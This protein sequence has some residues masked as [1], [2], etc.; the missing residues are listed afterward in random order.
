MAKVPESFPAPLPEGVEHWPGRLD[1]AAQ[2]ALLGAVRERVAR[3]PLFVPRMPRTGRAMSVR[4]TNFG[5]LGWVTDRA[6]GYRYQERHPETGAAWPDIPRMLMDLW[7]EL[8]GDPRAPQACLVNF[9][10][11]NAKMGL[12]QDRDEAVFDAPVLSVSLG[13]DAR[14]RVGGTQRGARTQSFRL[15]SGDVVRLGGPARLAHHGVDRIYAGTSDLLAGPGRVN[16][17]LRRVTA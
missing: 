6:G 2:E 12:H 9:Y 16:L 4:M 11:E 1:R 17:T 14:F 5:A 13:D 3:S 10:D 8:A 7:D 15:A